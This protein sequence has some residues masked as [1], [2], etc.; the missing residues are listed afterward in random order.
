MMDLYGGAGWMMIGMAGFWLLVIGVLAWAIVWVF[1]RQ[2]RV[3]ED[4]RQIL[5]RRF[6]SGEIDEA[7]Y[8]ASVDVLNVPHRR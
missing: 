3:G 6:A 8:R 4:P 7:T 1:P 2:P 5:D